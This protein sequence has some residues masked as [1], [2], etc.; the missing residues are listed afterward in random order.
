ML[1]RIAK[2]LNYRTG[3]AVRRLRLWLNHGRTDTVNTINTDQ[4]LRGRFCPIPFRQMDLYSDG[5]V[6]VCCPRWLPDYVGNLNKHDLMEVWNSDVAQSIRTSIFDGSFRHCDHKVCPMIQNDSLPTLAEAAREPDM[7]AIIQQ[8]AV[9][10]EA[11]PGFVNLAN[12]ESCNLSCPSCRQRPMNFNKGQEYRR[13]RDLQEKLTRQLFATP[14]DR[15]FTVNVTGS[16]D[17][18]ASR[19]FRDFLFRLD[20]TDFPNLDINLQ[21]NGVLFTPRNWERMAKI[22]AR[23][24]AV[25]VSFDAAT[26]ATYQITRRGGHWGQLHKNMRFLSALRQ[27]GKLRFLRLDFVVQ[28]DNYREMDEFVALG[29]SYAVDRVM[30]SMLL[31][32]GTWSH[33]VFLDKCIW[34]TQHPQ[35]NDFL[36]V[37]R[38]PVF[39]DPIVD[40]GNLSAYRQRA[41]SVAA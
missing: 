11:G 29:R 12:D 16:G 1:A 19:V 13:R 25:L 10:L 14:T 32:W 15:H 26:E 3:K 17:P 9:R 27:A 31:D 34:K 39:D 23:I 5:R 22:H 7:Q 18:F 4:D 24:N 37:L 36:A 38:D 20:G 21:T 28:K 6:S 33:A 2:S 30:F 8:R 40:L 41:V 35:Y